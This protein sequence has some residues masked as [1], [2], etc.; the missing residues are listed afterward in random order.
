MRFMDYFDFMNNI[1]NHE[2]LEY[3]KERTGTEDRGKIYDDLLTVISS[4]KIQPEDHLEIA[5][6]LESTGWNDEKVIETFGVHDVFDLSQ[7]LWEIMQSHAVSTS[8]VSEDKPRSLTVFYQAIRNFIRGAV[9]A[10]P[11]AISVF[12]MLGM[13]FSL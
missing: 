13:G 10:L 9:F 3:F 2:P 12:A 6:I 5:A 11:M 8:Y 1:D 4:R 7:N